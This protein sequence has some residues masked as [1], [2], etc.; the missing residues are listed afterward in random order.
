MFRIQL[1]LLVACLILSTAG[2]QSRCSNG[3]GGWFAENSTVAPPPTYSLNIPSVAKNQPYYTPGAAAPNYN[4]LNP[5]QTAPTPAALQ[6]Q[7]GWRQSGNQLSNGADGNPGEGRSVLTSPTTFVENQS[8]RLNPVRAPGNQQVP[9]TAALPGTGY[10]YTDSANY[11][12]TQIDES[13]DATRLPVTDAS[14]VRAPASFFPA[15]NVAQFQQTNPINRGNYSVPLQQTYVA[16]NGFN[17]Q[18][19]AYSGS[20]VLV[21][22]Q[23]TTYQGQAT[24]VNPAGYVNPYPTGSSPSVTAQSTSGQGSSSQLGWRNREM[25]SDNVNRF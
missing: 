12:T 21:G 10:S 3:C 4:T 6:N 1:L 5:N 11:R 20:T 13:R 16:Q 18:P 7:N 25:N 22:G 24:L 9:Q 19:A 15:G 17:Q 14:T 8:N 23:P 2:C